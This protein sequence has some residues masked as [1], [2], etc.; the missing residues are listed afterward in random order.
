M[1]GLFRAL[2]VLACLQLN[3]QYEPIGLTGINEL[4]EQSDLLFAC[5]VGPLI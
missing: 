4:A 5:G 2:S 1:L 3:L